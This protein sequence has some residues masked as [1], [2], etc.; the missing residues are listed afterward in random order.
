MRPRAKKQP[1]REAAAIRF[2]V[3]G[4]ERLEAMLD[5]GREVRD[6]MRVLA[7]SGG[8]VVAELLRDTATFYEWDHYP[9]GDVY[10]R[11]THAQY[12]YHA[13]PEKERPGEHGHFHTFL[14]PAGMPRGIK[15]L[16]AAGAPPAEP[17]AA[18]SHLIAIGM[19]RFGAPVA[20]FT[21]NR[22]VTDETWYRAEDVIRML[23]FFEIDLAQPSWP[24]NRW[25][26]AMIPLFRPQIE[27]LV[28]KRDEALAAWHKKKPR[29]NVYEDRGLDVASEMAI[30]VERQIAAVE[31]A[32]ENAR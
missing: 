5:A 18:L 17:N 25:I 15:P 2:A 8:N 3:L 19:D 30:D 23:D 13:H 4:R 10:D 24:V 1:Q 9:K 29:A 26:G 16:A 14:R 22:W 27:W 28:K 21:T 11:A 6:C 20:L 12:Y 32:L 31:Q 7:K